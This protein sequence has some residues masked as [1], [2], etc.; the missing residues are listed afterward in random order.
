MDLKKENDSNKNSVHSKLS[1][2]ILLWV[3]DKL[4]MFI[5]ICY[6]N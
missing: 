2:L 1:L 5:M 6:K 4:I 3:F